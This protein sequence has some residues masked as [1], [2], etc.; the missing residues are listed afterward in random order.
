MNL[1]FQ[2][3]IQFVSGEMRQNLIRDLWVFYHISIKNLQ[4]CT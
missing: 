2:H 1:I 4:R 3:E